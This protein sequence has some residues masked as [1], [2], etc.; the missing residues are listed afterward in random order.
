MKI[1]TELAA[2]MAVECLDSIQGA[3][4][5]FAMLIAHLHARGLID[6]KELAGLLREA[7][8]TAEQEQSPAQAGMPRAVAHYC[9]LMTTPPAGASPSWLRGV[10]RGG[11]A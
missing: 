2:G 1:T 11:K 7:G 8:E 6:P 3:G 5:T 4:Y 10:I 9:D